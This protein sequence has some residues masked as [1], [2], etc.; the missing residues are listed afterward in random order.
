MSWIQENRRTVGW[1]AATVICGVAGILYFYRGFFFGDPTMLQ[2]NAGDGALTMFISGHWS[3]ELQAMNALRDLGFFYPAPDTLG[4]SDT[5]FLFGALEWPMTVLGIPAAFRFQAALVVLSGLG[6]ASSVALL[7]LGPRVSWPFAIVGALVFAFG[8]GVYLASDHPQLLA[9]NVLP[10]IGLLAVGAR[11]LRSWRSVMAALGCGLLTG[12]VAYSAF[13]IGWF[14]LLSLGL[15]GILVVLFGRAARRNV[16]SL[17]Q[18]LWPLAGFVAGLGVGLVPFAYTYGPVLAEGRQRPIGEMLA[19][20]LT[21][22]DLFNVGPSNLLWGRLVSQTGLLPA[23][24]AGNGEFEMAPTPVLILAA[25]V[26]GVWAARRLRSQTAWGHVGLASVIV[27]LLF[28]VAP[29]KV[30]A[31]FPW[32]DSFYRLPGGEAVRAI[33]RIELASGAMLV[34]GGVILLNLWWKQRRDSLSAAWIAAVGVLVGVALI[35]QVQGIIVQDLPV[36]LVEQIASVPPPPAACQS[37]VVTA[38]RRVDDAPYVPQTEAALI[39]QRVGIPT[40]NGYSGFTPGGWDLFDVGDPAYR[41]HVNA[42]GVS[43]GVLEHGCGLDLATGT[44]LGPAA[45]RRAISEEDTALLSGAR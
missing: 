5:M 12:L 32:A 4:Y 40:W 22:S 24:H 16:L 7:R 34:F 15:V 43:H 27:G 14:I 8:S 18:A 9:L 2:G 35:E 42:W 6:Y 25:V 28:W 33:G 38:K 44:W 31:V 21:P 26:L 10:L 17:K 30:G 39:S 13:Y 37:F 19:F 1:F 36:A 45:L 29:L 20:A 11:R 23:A 3:A 41:R